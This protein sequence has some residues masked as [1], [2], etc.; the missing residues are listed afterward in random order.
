M[1]TA[2]PLRLRLGH[3]RMHEAI[4]TAVAV[5]SVVLVA[6]LDTPWW[7]VVAVA[8]WCAG[9]LAIAVRRARRHAGASLIIGMDRSL[10]VIDEEGAVRRGIVL[11]RTYVTAFLT[12]I[13]WRPADARTTRCIVVWPD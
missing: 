3:S 7:S 10:A 6:L 11:D 1:K 4:A 13:V 2:P 8:S 9:S 5:A 12:T